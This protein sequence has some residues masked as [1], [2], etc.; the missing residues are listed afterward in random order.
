MALLRGQLRRPIRND[1]WVLGAV[2]II[3]G[4]LVAAIPS[5]ETGANVLVAVRLFLVLGP[6][7]ALFKHLGRGPRFEGKVLR[8]YV[9]GSA[10]SAAVA[11]GQALGVVGFAQVPGIT[12]RFLGLAEHF[13]DLGGTL[14]IGLVASIFGNSTLARPV[15]VLI[16]LTIV[17]GLFLSGSVT[18]NL[19]ASA[20]IAWG[21]YRS[22]SRRHRR[23]AFAVVGLV[24]ATL[25]VVALNNRSTLEDRLQVVTKGAGGEQGTLFSRIDSMS[26]ALH[27][28]EDSPLLGR[29]SS[30]KEAA[31][32][33]DGTAT[34]N[35]VLLYWY[36][37]GLLG[38]LGLLLVLHAAT[39]RSRRRLAPA[40]NAMLVAALIYSLTAPIQFHRYFWLPV[41]M[42][43]ACR[44]LQTRGSKSP[45]VVLA[46]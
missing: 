43:L 20:G 11:A 23:A 17:I 3:S 38:V 29:G 2:F 39:R 27:R 37:S 24:L 33:K 15:R 12:N 21:F 1:L 28:I 42:A 35:I 45:R 34:H 8:W 14:A 36:Q 41:L 40:T 19:A 46:A 32:L 25:L 5:E 31:V 13:N 7:A 10:A 26:S 16:P 18:G 4:L 6:F 30:A 22:S 44:P 9:Y